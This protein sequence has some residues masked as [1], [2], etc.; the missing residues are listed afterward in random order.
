MREN[1]RAGKE[2]FFSKSVLVFLN[3]TISQPKFQKGVLI[4]TYILLGLG[5]RRLVLSGALFLVF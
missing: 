4:E 5:V 3:K 2:A 1:P